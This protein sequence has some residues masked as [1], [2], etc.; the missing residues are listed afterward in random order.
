MVLII[1]LV[2]RWGPIVSL[3]EH[4]SGEKVEVQGQQN[5]ECIERELIPKTFFQGCGFCNTK[6][7]TL[8]NLPTESLILKI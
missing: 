7:H 1:D 8:M 4:L 6:I 3:K 2:S 5:S